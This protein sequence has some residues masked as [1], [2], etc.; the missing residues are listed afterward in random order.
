MR[1]PTVNFQ[2]SSEGSIS[3]KVGSPTGVVAS[4]AV[5]NRADAKDASPSADVGRGDSLI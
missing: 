5:T 4:V 1:D 2:L 3:C